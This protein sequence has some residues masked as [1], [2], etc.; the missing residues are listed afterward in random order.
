MQQRLV[1]N[2]GWCLLVAPVEKRPLWR[3]CES[4][5]V[6]FENLCDLQEALKEMHNPDLLVAVPCLWMRGKRDPKRTGVRLAKHV[7]PIARHYLYP[8][9]LANMNL[10]ELEVQDAEVRA[11]LVLDLW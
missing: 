11:K 5:M 1:M 7:L 6:V 8:G 4:G 9:S 2:L 3:V 10:A